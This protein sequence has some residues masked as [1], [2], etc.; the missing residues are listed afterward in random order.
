MFRV[1]EKV[2]ATALACLLVG[3]VVHAVFHAH[4]HPQNQGTCHVC[5]S[6]H[7][8]DAQ[9]WDSNPQSFFQVVGVVGHSFILFDEKP[10]SFD[11]LPRAPP[12]V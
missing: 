10:F 12:F 2:R 7:A 11:L 8:V 6:A 9:L 3:F 5:Q 4:T 1:A